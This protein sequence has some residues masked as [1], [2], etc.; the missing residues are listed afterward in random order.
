M[1]GFKMKGNSAETGQREREPAPFF[2][3]VIA[4]DASVH[5]WPIVIAAGEGSGADR[6]TVPPLNELKCQTRLI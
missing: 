1:A 4:Q 2:V 5:K 3:G 6:Q